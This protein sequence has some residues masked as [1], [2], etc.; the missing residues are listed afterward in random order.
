MEDAFDGGEAGEAHVAL[1]PVLVEEAPLHLLN[2]LVRGVE[3]LLV[4]AQPL[5]DGAQGGAQPLLGASTFLFGRRLD[6][7][8]LLFGR[9]L[10]CLTRRSRCRQLTVQSLDRGGGV[11]RGGVRRLAPL[12]RAHGEV[13]GREDCRR[14]RGRDCSSPRPR[15]QRR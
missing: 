3:A 7:A 2:A 11:A 12:A 13:G 1:L 15:W 8:Q 5:L 9:R 6:G 4:G 10:L 14:V